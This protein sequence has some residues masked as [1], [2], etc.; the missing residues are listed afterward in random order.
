[1]GEYRGWK[2]LLGGIMTCRVCGGH[3]KGEL[4]VAAKGGGFHLVPLCY[5]CFCELMIAAR[6]VVSDETL[7]S[8]KT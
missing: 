1:M 6:K 8:I 4:K 5:Q 7:C 3:P 2:E